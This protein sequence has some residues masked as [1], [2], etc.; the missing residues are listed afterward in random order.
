MLGKRRMLRKRRRRK[1]AEQ[2]QGLPK[3]GEGPL[4]WGVR[5]CKAASWS[6]LLHLPSLLFLSIMTHGGRAVESE[7]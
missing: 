4:E 6:Y 2:W 3:S 1:R 5:R 7:S